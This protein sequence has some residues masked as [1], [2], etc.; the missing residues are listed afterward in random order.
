VA[1]REPLSGACTP[2]FVITT[3]TPAPRAALF[4]ASRGQL[5]RDHDDAGAIGGKSVEQRVDFHLR[6]DVD[7][8]GRLVDDQDVG[9]GG[10]PLSEHHLLLVAAAQRHRA[11][12]GRGRLD[13]QFADPPCGQLALAPAAHHA[14][15]GQARQRRQRQVLGH[16][17]PEHQAVAFAVLGHEADPGANRVGGAADDERSPLEQHATRLGR[18]RPE[19]DAGELGAS[20][21]E[22]A[23]NTEN[24]AAV[25][26]E[27]D[28]AEPIPPRDALDPQDLGP[29]TAGRRRI[30]I[31]DVAVGHQPNQVCGGCGKRHRR[32]ETP[33]AEHGGPVTDPSELF[34]PMRDVD[35]A[36]TASGQPPDRREQS[37]DLRLGEGRGR[38]VHH[39][40]TGVER[41][42]L[43]HFYHLL[44][45]DAEQP[46]RRFGI[47]R[48]AEPG[49]QA[50]RVGGQPTAVDHTR[51]PHRLATQEDVRRRREVRDQREL[52]V[53]G[54][55]ARELGLARRV[56]RHGAAVEQ[57]LSRIAPAGA[58]QDLH[59]RRLAGAVLAEQDVHLART[60]LEAHI[61]EGDD[62]RVAFADA[63]HLQERRLGSRLAHRRRAS[64]WRASI[65]RTPPSA[66]RIPCSA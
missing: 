17:A 40:D 47:D 49:E 52:L 22:Q 44:F 62:A 1:R 29:A 18:I 45:G 14:G 48:H 39:Q 2:L 38:L 51:A 3:P 31:A 66:I 30:V 46:H 15:A 28:V 35:H 6:G 58:A 8:A 37:L 64:L 61:V 11:G 42:R 19:H 24:L 50:C 55:D 53:N 41:Q 56:E 10:E 9:A 32:H 25:Q 57:D 33:V 21:P 23:G 13:P 12:G 43:R 27:A 34:H 54:A 5:R 36:D 63:A 7:A 59:Q 60:Q 20:R 26:S 4:P 16:G 65:I